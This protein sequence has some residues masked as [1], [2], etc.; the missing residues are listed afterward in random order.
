[1]SFS[2]I[3]DAD[4]SPPGMTPAIAPRRFASGVQRNSGATKMRNHRAEN[5]PTARVLGT[6]KIVSLPVKDRVVLFD[7]E[8]DPRELEGIE[9]PTDPE[10]LRRELE[11]LGAP[12]SFADPDPALLFDLSDPRVLDRRHLERLRELGYTEALNEG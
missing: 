5:G 1:M 6:S 8:R 3:R 11:R 10:A 2:S 4:P 9:L 7:L 12:R